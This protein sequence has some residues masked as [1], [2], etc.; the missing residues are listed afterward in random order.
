MVITKLWAKLSFFYQKSIFRKN[1]R[2]F[3]V[4]YG[5]VILRSQSVTVIFRMTY[6]CHTSLAHCHC[7]H[8]APLL[9]GKPQPFSICFGV[10][11]EID[12]SQRQRDCS[13][14]F[15]P[16]DWGPLGR[17]GRSLPEEPCFSL[18]AAPD[19]HSQSRPR[20][21]VSQLTEA[22]PL[23]ARLCFWN[24]LPAPDGTRE[25]GRF[26]WGRGANSEFEIW[27]LAFWRASTALS[28]VTSNDR[29]WQFTFLSPLILS[30]V[31]SVVFSV[32]SDRT[33]SD[34]TLW[35]CQTV[36]KNCRTLTTHLTGLVTFWAHWYGEGHLTSTL[37]SPRANVDNV[38]NAI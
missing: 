18:R 14:C 6:E 27:G 26:G 33:R 2:E 32:L 13:Y 9:S 31:Y 24:P 34:C 15:S 20:G 30:L 25:D 11:V 3:S 23:R 5:A 21:S 1:S 22:L 17:M 28:R 8:P 29:E 4:Q 16:P 12:W 38:L 36:G 37:A 10:S 19:P 7:T 35:T